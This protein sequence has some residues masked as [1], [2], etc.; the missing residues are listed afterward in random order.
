MTAVIE[1]EEAYYRNKD[2]PEFQKELL[3]EYANRPS[4]LYFAKKMTSEL[5]GAI[6]GSGIVRIVAEHGRKSAGPVGDFV[7]S[8]K[9]AIKDL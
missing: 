6:V 9:D 5:G 1:L 2:D 4:R 7:K 3:N 8:M